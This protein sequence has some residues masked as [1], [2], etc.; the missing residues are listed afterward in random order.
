MG[1]I[2]GQRR[3]ARHKASLV[4]YV[5][6]REFARRYA[7][8]V[9]GAAWAM[10]FPLLQI[11][12][13]WAVAHYGLKVGGRGGATLGAMLVAGMTPWFALSESLTAMTV[14]LSGNAPLMKRLVVPVEIMPAAALVSAAFVHLAIVTVAVAA[15]WAAGYPPAPRL[16][17]ILYFGACAMIL[18]F[19]LGILLALANVVFRDVAQLLGPLLLLWFWATPVVWPRESLPERLQWIVTFNPLAY[20]V[21]GYRFAMLGEAAA[22][23]DAAAAIAFWATCALLGAA[24]WAAFRRFRYELAD[25]L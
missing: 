21:D 23:P 18:A 13:Y 9:L 12:V 8:S 17:S 10:A 1:T 3:S 19:A 5:A 15:L 22:R 20:L 11:A 4:L 14:S 24:A 16:L 7:G 2:T 25:L 6:R